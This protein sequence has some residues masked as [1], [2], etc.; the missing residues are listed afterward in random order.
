[1]PPTCKT[2]VMVVLFALL[3]IEDVVGRAILEDG[4]RK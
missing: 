4:C 1:M 2:I 3:L